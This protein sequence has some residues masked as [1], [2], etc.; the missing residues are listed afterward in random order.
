[1]PHLT[2]SEPAVTGAPDGVP[3]ALAALIE[4]FENLPPTL[5]LE[6][7]VEMGASVADV[8]ASLADDL[9]RMERV[10][11]CQS[12]VYVAVSVATAAPHT[13]TLHIIAPAEAPTTRGFAG[14][15]SEGLAGCSAEQILAVPTDLPHRLGLDGIISPLRLAG[16][17]SMQGRLQRLVSVRLAEL[18]QG[19]GTSDAGHDA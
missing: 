8:P 9:A 13:V 5:R 11:E 19:A 4:D 2:G 1:M 18:G 3:R 17:A 10:V 16:M 6:L 14:V 7:L 12:P 15:L